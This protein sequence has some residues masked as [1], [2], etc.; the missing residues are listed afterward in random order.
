LAAIASARGTSPRRNEPAHCRSWTRLDVRDRGPGW[1]HTGVQIVNETRG[2]QRIAK[3]L[4][5][6]FG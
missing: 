1:D 4:E 2:F 3:A 5:P 6:R